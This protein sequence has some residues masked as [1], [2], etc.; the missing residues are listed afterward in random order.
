MARWWDNLVGPPGG[1][2]SGDDDHGWANPMFQ[3]DHAAKLKQQ[4][5]GN[6]R[7]HINIGTSAINQTDH[8]AQKFQQKA[9]PV[10]NAL[11]KASPTKA[12]F[13]YGQ[14]SSWNLDN[15]SSATF[16]ADRPHGFPVG[17][18]DS[19]KGG[20][21]ESINDKQVRVYIHIK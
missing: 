7:T 5:R 12:N 19:F 17:H 16:T 6:G 18:R 8:L 9:Q 2:G 15:M 13:N 4:G 20:E 10:A 14:P 11:H 21:V 3:K 1:G